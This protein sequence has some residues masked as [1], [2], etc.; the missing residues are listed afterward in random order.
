L[1]HSSDLLNQNNSF[2]KELNIEIED[3]VIV[4]KRK[5]FVTVNSLVVFYIEMVLIILNGNFFFKKK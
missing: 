1:K 5:Q 3:L 4:N 2:T